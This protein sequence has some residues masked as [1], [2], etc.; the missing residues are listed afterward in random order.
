[1]PHPRHLPR[2]T[3]AAVLVGAALLA[4][5]CGSGFSGSGNTTQQSGKASLQ[6]LIGSS[7]NAETAAVKAAAASWSSSSGNTATVVPA[8]SMDQQ[9]GQA[10]AGPNPPDVFYLDA[11][12][13]AD[14][15]SVGALYPYGSQANGG[16]DFY[17]SLRSAFTYQGTFYCAPKDFST[18]GLVVNTDMWARAGLTDADIPTT[19]DQLTAVATRIKAAGMVPLAISP[20]H[21]RLDAFLAQAGGK[22]VDGT[23]P[24]ADSPQ[25]VQALTYVQGLLK[26]GLMSFSSALDTG[27][28]GEAFGKGKAAMTVEGN[29][30][31]GALKSDYPSVKY[32]VAALPAGP[33]GPATLEFTQCW[34]ISAKSK[35]HQQA[36]DFANAMTAPNQ[37]LAFAK[38]FGVVPSRHSLQ[39]AY[40]NQFPVDAAFVNSVP[41][42]V[43]PVN[44][45]KVASVLSDFDTQLQAL[46]TTDP[47]AILQRLQS[48]LAAALGS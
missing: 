18:L 17:P 38:A 16:S 28:G 29:W 46:A 47:K 43:G 26:G 31:E 35:H 39:S 19:W 5:A 21:D 23:K 1:M 33:A 10:F 32:K 14:Y 2:L 7:G 12:K 30:I 20:T 34:G 45:P 37:Q 36:V 44:A 4:S 8:Q 27:W 24:A 13:I 40:T 3:G 25:N 6:I 9:L 48:N 42:G 11:S 41:H 15:A 22:I